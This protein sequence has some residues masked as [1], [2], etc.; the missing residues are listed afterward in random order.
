[1]PANLKTVVLDL[2]HYSHWSFETLMEMNV[3]EL[4]DWHQTIPRD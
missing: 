2:A 3:V 1:M 4:L